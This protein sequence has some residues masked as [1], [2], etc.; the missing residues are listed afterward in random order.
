M[1]RD[2]A[3]TCMQALEE[4]DPRLLAEAESLAGLTADAGAAT[5]VST[6]K[7]H[8]HRPMSAAAVAACICAVALGVYLTLLMTANGTFRKIAA[9]FEKTGETESEPTDSDTDFPDISKMPA[10]PYEGMSEDDLIA[11]YAENEKGYGLSEQLTT[12]DTPLYFIYMDKH[13][14]GIMM[15]DKQ[16]GECLPVRAVSDAA[17]E[18]LS[19]IW[20]GATVDTE[21][22]KIYLITLTGTSLKLWKTDLRFNYAEPIREWDAFTDTVYGLIYPY[23]NANSKWFSTGCSILAVRHGN[24]RAD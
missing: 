20:Q 14:K 7:K 11:L 24:R 13:E 15:F 10:N 19:G 17:A 9:F 4:L 2:Y 6:K 18:M 12:I 1:K 23:S 8:E 22:G 5:P 3:F 21:T 16:S